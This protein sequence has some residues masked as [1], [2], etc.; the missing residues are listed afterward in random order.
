MP[1]VVTFG[2]IMLRLSPPGFERFL[3]TSQ[4]VATFGGGE[5]NVAVSLAQFGV[6]SWY[7]T[8]LP[9]HAIGDAAVKALRAEGVRTE[10]ILRGGDR[11]GVYYAESGAS[12]R[13][14]VV[15]YDRAR[16]AISEIDPASVDWHATFR[17][18]TWFHVTGI[19]PALGAKAA[20]ATRDA[21]AA[22]R[23]AGARV[24]IDLNFRRKLWT[25]A[26]AQ[27]VM[28][29]LVRDID[30]VIA[31]EEDLQATLGIEVTGVHVAGG[32]LDVQAYR[33]AAERVSTELGVKAV[34]ITLRESQSASD[35]GWSA[36]L[37]DAA[38]ARVP[39]EP[40][41]R[42][43]AGRSHRRR[44]QLRGRADLRPGDRPVRRR[45]APVRGRGERLEADDSCRLQ[46]RH[47]GRSGSAGRRRR[48]GTRPAL[49][50]R[51]SKLTGLVQDLTTGS[52]TRH[53]LKTSSFMLVTMVFQ[54]LYFLIDLYW[55]GR[56]GTRSGGRRR[57]RG[58]R[59]VRRARDHA[60]ARWSGTTTLVSHAVGRKEHARALYVFNQALVLSVAAG[61]IFFAVATFV[62]GLY[63]STLGAD[64]ATA[65]LAD[66]YLRWFIPAMALQFVMAPMG[67][68]LRGTGNFRPGMVVQTSTVILNMVLAPFLIFGWGTGTGARRRR[69]GDL[70]ARRA[71]DRHD[72]DGDVL[73][74]RRI[75]PDLRAG[76]LETG[77]RGVAPRARHRA[78]GRRRVRADGDLSLHHL[79]RH[80]AVR[81]GRAGRLRHRAADYPGRLHAGRG[82]RLLGRAGRRAELRRGP[83][84]PCPRHVSRRGDPRRVRHG[85][86][87]RALPYRAGRV[88]P[89]L[90]ERSG[91]RARRR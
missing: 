57:A 8:R 26:E 62:R 85:R 34:A 66:D 5:A 59:D 28:R 16:S 64:A 63:T 44:R 78:S 32:Q 65:A 91:C 71:R 76:G 36:V 82:A 30:L 69:R 1:K 75:V 11:I 68:A 24:S 15:I 74:A 41:L 73:H 37:W 72:L 38:S 9:A 89:G 81:R 84:C 4:F 58:Q 67:A 49:G 40:A 51:S 19:T 47:G 21:I 42:R 22:A 6:E 18:A 3:Q 10:A 35:N 45:R 56:L 50:R 17:G 39:S 80:P 54:T 60:D 43:A 83:S 53:L 86:A 14:S 2:E 20:T 52:V 31:N 79:R 55:V 87:H 12:Q 61:L 88:D 29:P 46:S 77:P 27:Q 7:V 25:E 13:A 70:V 23:A 90:L 33:A 48:L